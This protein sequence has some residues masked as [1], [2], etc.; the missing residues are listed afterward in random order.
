MIVLSLQRDESSLY[1]DVDITQ[2]QPHIFSL[3]ISISGLFLVYRQ[4]CFKIFFANSSSFSI[5]RKKDRWSSSAYINLI[6]IA[7]QQ[8]WEIHFE[9]LLLLLPS[10]HQWLFFYM[11]GAHFLLFFS[12]SVSLKFKLDISR[13]H[14]YFIY[15]LASC[16]CECAMHCLT[17]PAT[18]CEFIKSMQKERKTHEKWE[19]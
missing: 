18:L 9:F 5:K 15:F 16:F 3:P 17:L 19:L 1:L 10:P 4:F 11:L 6:F 8:W 13:L 2:S 12:F 7:T 14:F